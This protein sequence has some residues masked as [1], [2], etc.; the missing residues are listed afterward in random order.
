M[1]TTD[2][3]AATARTKLR[4]HQQHLADL[5]GQ[6][7]A[8][9]RRIGEF[10]STASAAQPAVTNLEALRAQRRQVMAE[11]ALGE[12]DATVLD[13]ADQELEAAEVQARTAARG[14]EIAQAGAE[15]L[16]REHAELADQ[17]T[18]ASK[19]TAALSYY[20]AVEAAQGKVE[21]YRAALSAMGGAYADLMGACIAADGFADPSA[22][23][24]RLFVTG[25]MRSAIF[26]A[27]L[28]SLPGLN[29]ALF[30]FDF[31]E[32]VTAATAA[33]LTELAG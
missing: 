25:Q 17:I 13:L 23:A 21:A 10:Q 7:N 31:S 12:S 14:I 22:A 5:I 19:H 6:A 3:A 18:T 1:T 29:G 30:D 24:L 4:S 9:Q 28:P 11:V 20:A 33:A 27:P 16:G 26:G 32:Q 2:T 15:R 8:L